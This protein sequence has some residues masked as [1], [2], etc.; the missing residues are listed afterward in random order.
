MNAPPI[1][2]ATL[3][4]EEAWSAMLDPE[5][6]DPETPDPDG[7]M[8]TAEG[9]AECLCATENS[10]KKKKRSRSVNNLP[11]NNLIE[12]LNFPAKPRNKLRADG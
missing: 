8:G 1:S 12:R 5:M 10:A 6:L 2:E 9:V 7:G 3:T 11:E 4:V